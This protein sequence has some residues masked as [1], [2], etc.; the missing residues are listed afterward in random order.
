ML[1]CAG[2]PA[3]AVGGAGGA[4]GALLNEITT[5]ET[6]WKLSLGE[7]KI[8]KIGKFGKIKEPA[9]VDAEVT[10]YVHTLESL[11]RL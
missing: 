11:F 3:G 5:T 9:L 2:N 6:A 8:R 1:Y 4:G 10:Y 7:G